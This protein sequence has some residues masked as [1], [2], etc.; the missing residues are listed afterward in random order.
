MLPTSRIPTHPGEM[1]IEEFL[2]PLGITQSRLAAHLG[3][4]IQRI[5]EVVNGK[6]G[7]TPET[8]LLLSAALGTSAEF[9]INLQSAHDL[10]EARLSND[11]LPRAI[12]SS[13]RLPAMH[14]KAK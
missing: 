13:K 1:L 2:N 9:W 11:R 7:I 3:I 4:P 6:R 8:A 14:R 10:A 12:F 5:N